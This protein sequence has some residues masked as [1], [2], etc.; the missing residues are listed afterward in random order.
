[1]STTPLRTL[2]ALFIA[3]TSLATLAAPAAA[4]TVISPCSGRCGSNDGFDEP[5]GP[6]GAVCKYD[7]TTLDLATIVVHPPEI[8]SL[9]AKLTKVGWRYEIYGGPTDTNTPTKL[10]TSTWQFA[11]ASQTKP[12][13][14]GHG[15]TKRS[16]HFTSDPSAYEWYRV[17]IDVGWWHNGAREGI[18]SFEYDWYKTVQ[19]THT[20]SHEDACSRTAV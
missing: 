18:L 6:F 19:G 8:W 3:V 12:V 5:G 16:Y 11:K 9:Y 15:L 2:V 14:G 1:M 10:F 13:K 20:G 4:E 7:N 17:V